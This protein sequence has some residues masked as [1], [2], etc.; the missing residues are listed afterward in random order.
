M[1]QTKGWGSVCYLETPDEER[2]SLLSLVGPLFAASPEH[3][4]NLDRSGAPHFQ[5]DFQSQPRAQEACGKGWQWGALHKGMAPDSA[6][7]P[8]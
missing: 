6:T 2:S 4:E 3:G 5:K 7:L 8:A 1:A